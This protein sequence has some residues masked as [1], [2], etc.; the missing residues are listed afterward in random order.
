[1]IRNKEK[2]MEGYALDLDTKI[3]MAEANILDFYHK[4]DG[5]VYIAFSGGKDST[6]L[7]H[8]IRNIIPDMKA[9]FSDTGLEYPEIR[10]F[11]RKFDNVEWLRPEISFR[12]S[13]LDEGYPL[14]SKEVASVIR[15]A[16]RNPDS[17][18]HKLLSGE[19]KGKSKFDISNHA[20]LLD[21]PFKLNDKC[22]YTFKKSPFRKYNTRSN[23]KGSYLGVRA[24]ESKMRELSWMN[25]GCNLYGTKGNKSMPLSLW[26]DKDIDEYIKRFNLDL[27]EIYYKGYD[28]TGCMFCAFGAH[29]EHYPNRFQLMEKTHPQLHAY[30]LKPIEE[31]GLGMKEPLDFIK[32]PY[33][34]EYEGLLLDDIEKALPPIKPNES[35][36]KYVHRCMYWKKIEPYFVSREYVKRCARKYYKNKMGIYP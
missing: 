28:R 19:M 2:L 4:L 16:Q 33:K 14:I 3:H 34:D 6:V 35:E 32:V 17:A 26:T 25:H 13:I 8:L 12:Q 10:D 21:A 23:M 36:A 30:L 31:G 18:K 27:A 7:I 22:C 24:Q 1:M 29:L 9:V 15:T 11:V 20:Y 5:K